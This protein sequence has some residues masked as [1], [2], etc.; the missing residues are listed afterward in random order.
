MVSL[1]LQVTHINRNIHV[2]AVISRL[3]LETDFV[4]SLRLY[5][6][7]TAHPQRLNVLFFILLRSHSDLLE[8]L[9]RSSRCR[10]VSV[11]F[12]RLYTAPQTRCG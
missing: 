3:R 2:G 8:L 1:R 11:A 9:L 12:I 4:M 6:A 7:L 5:R 10:D